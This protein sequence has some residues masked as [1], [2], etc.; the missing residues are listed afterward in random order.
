[1]K[2]KTISRVEES[3]TRDCKGDRLQVHRNRDPSL[4]PFEKVRSR[5]SCCC[6]PVGLCPGPETQRAVYIARPGSRGQAGNDEGSDKEATFVLNRRIRELAGG[7]LSTAIIAQTALQIVPSNV[8]A[9]R[10]SQDCYRHP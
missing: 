6:R 3:Y 9:R 8:R 7:P 2:V 4:H 1:M 5:R 10:P